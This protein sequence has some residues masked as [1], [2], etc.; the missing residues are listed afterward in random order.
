MTRRR[1]PATRRVLAHETQGVES[2]LGH[3]G[4]IVDE[5]GP[6]ESLASYASR[7]DQVVEENVRAIARLTDPYDA[8]DVLDLMRQRE[9]PLTLTGHN[10][11]NP[12]V[13]LQPS[14]SL[15]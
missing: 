2:L 1:P 3:M 9:T 7:R 12:T 8:Y 13:A 15:Q 14:R 5:L 10:E 11:A 6:G 4:R